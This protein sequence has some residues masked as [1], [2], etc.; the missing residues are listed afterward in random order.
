MNLIDLGSK[1][2]MDPLQGASRSSET[3]CQEDNRMEPK[4]AEGFELALEINIEELEDRAAP[5]ELVWP[6]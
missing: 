6:F 4:N 3:Y 1:K 2:R 5:G